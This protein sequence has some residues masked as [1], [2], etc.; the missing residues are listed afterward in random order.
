VSRLSS[1]RR[2]RNS[3]FGRLTRP[4]LRPDPISPRAARGA[5]VKAG[6]ASAAG[7]LALTE[8]ARCYA[9]LRRSPS[10]SRDMDL[11][12]CHAAAPHQLTSGRP[13]TGRHHH[14]LHERH[15]IQKKRDPSTGRHLCPA[16]SR[17][18]V[19]P[20][21]RGLRWPPNSSFE[22]GASRDHSGL[23]ISPEC[24]HKLSCHS[25]D[26][27]LPDPAVQ[28]ADPLVIPP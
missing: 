13:L 18:H 24:N 8:R 3:S 9:G 14:P 28:R 22:N 6:I 26:R 19:C 1:V 21:D 17:S 25:N 20:G 15:E 10:V 23:E 16:N 2:L 5:E 12:P 7:A 11:D 27:D 4:F